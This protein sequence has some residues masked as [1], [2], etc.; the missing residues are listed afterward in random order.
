MVDVHNV[1]LVLSI[2]PGIEN[3]LFSKA[4]PYTIY[5]D[6][7]SRFV[8]ILLR[9]QELSAGNKNINK[10]LTNDQSNQCFLPAKNSQMR[11]CNKIKTNPDKSSISIFYLRLL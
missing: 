8:L 9:M 2:T 5:I 6:D 10:V 4:F 3:L 7:L 1:A 11:M